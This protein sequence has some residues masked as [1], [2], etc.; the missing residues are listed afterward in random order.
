MK[1]L[2]RKDAGCRRLSNGACL[3]GRKF[4]KSARCGGKP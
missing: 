2:A 3:C 1:A 4:A